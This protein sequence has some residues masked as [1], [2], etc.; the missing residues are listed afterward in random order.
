MPTVAVKLVRGEY[1]FEAAD[2]AGLTMT[3][4]NSRDGGG[5]GLGVSPMQSLLM[6][7]GG[8]SGIDMVLI[9]KKQ[10]QVI[11]AF[12]MVISGEREKDKAPALWEEVHV[13]FQLAG[14]IDP[15]KAWR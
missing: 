14:D 13:A 5:T 8:C 11:D 1:G 9:L 6:A 15:D 2:A 10:R 12:R 7:L 4:D 3:M